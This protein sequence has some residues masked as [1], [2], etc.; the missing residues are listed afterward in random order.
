MTDPGMRFTAAMARMACSRLSCS[1]RS[2]PRRTATC[3]RYTPRMIR[4]Q[5]PARTRCRIW[6]G[7]NPARSASS[8]V[9]TG[10]NPAGSGR[11][12]R[13]IAPV[14]EIRSA[15]CLRRPQ[16]SRPACAVRPMTTPPVAPAGRS[17]RWRSNGERDGWDRVEL[18]RIP[19]DC[20]SGRHMRPVAR[21]RSGSHGSTLPWLVDSYVCTGCVRDLGPGQVGTD[22]GQLAT[23]R[24]DDGITSQVD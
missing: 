2:P 20:A 17:G 19:A 18:K 9:I 5:T 6:S 12:L 22:A 24:W 16:G 23:P 8:Q 21:S 1:N 3:R 15:T 7:E 11:A 14:C 4:I 10:G 13:G